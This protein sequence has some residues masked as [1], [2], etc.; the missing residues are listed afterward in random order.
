[1]RTVFVVQYLNQVYNLH[2]LQGFFIVVSCET[3]TTILCP[4]HKI[5]VDLSFTISELLND[6]RN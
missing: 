3:K 1:M 4:V 6:A 2:N 5:Y